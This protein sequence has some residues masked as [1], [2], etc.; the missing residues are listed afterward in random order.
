MSIWHGRQLAQLWSLANEHIGRPHKDERGEIEVGA[1]RGKRLL[2]FLAQSGWAFRISVTFFWRAWWKLTICLCGDDLMTCAA[3]GLWRLGEKAIPW[4]CRGLWPVCSLG[5]SYSLAVGLLP[6]LS[7]A[8]PSAAP[9]PGKRLVGCNLA[10]WQFVLTGFR[11]ST[12]DQSIVFMG[13]ISTTHS[14]IIRC[15]RAEMAGYSVFSLGKS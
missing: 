10:P 15:V 13:C 2:P 1:F 6:P 4:R 3:P 7:Q 9:E 11:Q 14:A 8:R 12:E 5:K